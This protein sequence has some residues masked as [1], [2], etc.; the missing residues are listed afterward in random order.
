MLDF[1]YI[2][3]KIQMNE[4]RNAFRIKFEDGSQIET[5]MNTDLKG[6]KEYYIGRKFNLGKGEKDKMV[7]AVKVEQ[8]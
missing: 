2:L 1:N 3:K 4:E 7:K 5:E 8:I 6:A